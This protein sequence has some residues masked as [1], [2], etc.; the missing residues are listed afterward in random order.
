LLLLA[1]SVVFLAAANRAIG[2]APP[3]ADKDNVAVRVGD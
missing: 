1:W 3:A 2:E